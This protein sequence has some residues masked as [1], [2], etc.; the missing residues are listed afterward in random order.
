MGDELKNLHVWLDYQPRLYQDLILRVLHHI[1]QSGIGV[2][3]V[4][5][6][7]CPED[8]RGEQPPVDII[9]QSLDQIM[10]RPD[11]FN[12][13]DSLTQVIR[14]AFSPKGNQGWMRQTSNNQW[15]LIR[16]FGL[17]RLLDE[18]L[19]RANQMI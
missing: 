1:N 15:E 9:L 2:N 16:P 6:S 14:I 8:Q 18:L 10:D 12:Q 17:Q 11:R 4:L 13:D 5:H 3:L 7:G 19:E